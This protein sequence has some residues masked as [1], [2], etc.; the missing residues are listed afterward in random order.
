MKKLTLVTLL[1][2]VVGLL[3]AGTRKDRKFILPGD[4]AHTGVQGAPFTPGILHGDTLY[5]S[6]QLG[7]DPKTG[8]IPDDY[9][10]EVRTCL[11]NVQHVLKEGGMDYSDVDSVQVY[12]T[13]VK[14]FPRM[15]AVYT[16]VFKFPRPTRST[17][18]VSALVVPGA[19]IEIS[20][21]ARK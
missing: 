18:G 9:E 1:L 14:Q 19:H 21:T 7:I 4:L 20:A 8:K 17:V 11:Q 13:D 3:S 15:N 2:A 6:G 5:V 12:L 10:L 16:S